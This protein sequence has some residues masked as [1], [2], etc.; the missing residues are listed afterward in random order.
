MES[1]KQV[2]LVTSDKMT[3]YR[4]VHDMVTAVVFGDGAAAALI[5]ETRRGHRDSSDRRCWG[6]MDAV[7]RAAVFPIVPAGGSRCPHLGRN[8]PRDGRHQRQPPQPGAVAHG[9]NRGLQFHALD[10]PSRIRRLLTEIKR[11]QEEIDLFLLHQANGFML[12]GIRA[13]NSS[14]PEQLPI[15]IAEIGNTAGAPRSPS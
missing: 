9:W 15:D 12:D 8:G 4:N 5:N 3:Q 7:H 2:L 6:P 1:A 10:G 14:S 13:Q 11:D